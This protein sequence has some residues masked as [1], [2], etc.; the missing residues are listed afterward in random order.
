MEGLY[1]KVLRG[2]YEK[3][4]TVYST[5]LSNVI[6]AMLQVPA[7]LRPTCKKILETPSVLKRM[8]ELHLREGDGKL[9]FLK[10]IIVP[11]N[12][13]MLSETL[14]PCNYEPLK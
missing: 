4:P 14:P 12:M 2:Y 9:D 1:K 3:I 6:K 11:K 13:Q 5:D 7:H 10:T 8:T